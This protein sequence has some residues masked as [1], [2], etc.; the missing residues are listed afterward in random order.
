MI[1]DSKKE[2]KIAGCEMRV[3]WKNKAVQKSFNPMVYVFTML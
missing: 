3:Y 1:W 2:K